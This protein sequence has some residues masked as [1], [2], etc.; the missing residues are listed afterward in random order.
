MA[1]F[2]SND[3]L[4][5]TCQCG[6]DDAIHIKV[7][8]DD[9]NGDVCLLTYMNSNFY[10]EQYGAFATFIKKCKKVWAVIRNKD[11]HYSEIIMNR[12]D[13]VKFKMYLCNV[14]E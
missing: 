5:A 3:E 7:D 12:D 10:K 9:I 11:Y 4:I 6:C 14:K 8:V 2:I 13:F 1:V